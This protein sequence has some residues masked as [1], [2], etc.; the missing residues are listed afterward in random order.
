VAQL[1]GDDATA[2]IVAATIAMAHGLGLRVT[3]EGVETERQLA[4]LTEMG[5]DEAQGYYFGRPT[6]P[7]GITDFLVGQA[8]HREPAREAVVRSLP[9]PRDTSRSAS[10]ASAAGTS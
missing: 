5:C 1:Q 9:Q 6:T 10:S 8:T 2:T 7:L 4:R 3:A